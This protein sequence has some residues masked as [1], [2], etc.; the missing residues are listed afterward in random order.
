MR[1][2]R[3]LAQAAFCLSTMTSLAAAWPTW[4]EDLHLAARQDEG[5]EGAD[6]PKETKTPTASTTSSR[7]SLNTATERDPDAPRETGTGTD[8]ATGTKTGGK[9][10]K[11]QEREEFDIRDAV[12]RAALV[13]PNPFLGQ[14]LIKAGEIVVWVWNYTDVQA[15]PNAI[16]VILSLPDQDATWTLAANRTFDDPQTFTWDTNVQRTDPAKQLI[17]GKYQLIVKDSEA[18][19]DDRG[20]AGYLGSTA[21][22]LGIYK[23]REPIKLK[24]WTCPTCENAAPPALNQK[25]LA[26]ASSMALISVFTFT[27]FVAGLDL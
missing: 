6:A 25:G 23:P 22:S 9:S 21:F 17:T 13:T 4:M 2:V 20:E 11:T 27:W 7:K 10:T 16:D 5:E 12:G 1:A 19:L 26:F 24:D 18:S 8:K 3:T 15:E 14:P